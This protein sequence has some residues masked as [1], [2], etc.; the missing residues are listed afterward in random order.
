MSQGRQP[1]LLAVMAREARAAAELARLTMNPVFR[2]QG[3][4]RGN[5][6]LVLVIPGLFG[7][8]L[9]LEPLHNWL[10]RI[11]YR[12]IT[13][14]I[15]FNAGCSER[16]SHQVESYLG[17]HVVQGEQVAIIGH[18]RGGLLAKA[19][20]VRLGSLCSHLIFLA[21]PVGGIE[22]IRIKDIVDFQ[23]VPL[24]S[25]V[26]RAGLFV[27]GL[28]DPDCSFPACGCPFPRDLQSP[29]DRATRV[30][31]V[32]TPTDEIVSPTACRYPGAKNVEVSGTHSGMAYNVGA[33]R[34]IADFLTPATA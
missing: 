24:A 32:F 17:R 27:R 29:L 19:M 3:V 10:R 16:I 28:L 6:R 4:P 12:T 20:A 34:A 30:L 18:S 31:S 11:G 23:D 5:G 9:Y 14:T 33:Y 15:A 22:R 26:A 7:N 1:N 2:G 21:S 13:S 25:G 8:D